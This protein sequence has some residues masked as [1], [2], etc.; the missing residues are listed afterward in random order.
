MRPN[1]QLKNYSKISEELVLTDKKK[2]NELPLELMNKMNLISPIQQNKPKRKISGVDLID[3]DEYEEIYDEELIEKDEDDFS[4]SDEEENKFKF[5]ILKNR[6]SFDKNLN[7]TFSQNYIYINNLL[8]FEKYNINKSFL[9]YNNYFSNNLNLKSEDNSI[10]SEGNYSNN[11][12]KENTGINENNSISFNNNISNLSADKSNT[13]NY[14]LQNSVSQIT[15]NS[16][17]FNLNPNMFFTKLNSSNSKIIKT[18]NNNESSYN[19][20]SINT[21]NNIDNMVQKLLITQS[22][23]ENASNKNS[24]NEISLDINNAPFIPRNLINQKPKQEMTSNINTEKLTN[25]LNYY[26]N[27][28]QNFDIK[29]KFVN[30]ENYFIK[31]NITNSNIYTNN[32]NFNKHLN[33]KKNISNN[34]LKNEN[35]PE[36]KIRK[37]D[38]KDYLIEMFGKLG[39]ICDKCENFNFESRTTCNR[40]LNIKE[41]KTIEEINRIRKEKEEKKKN[42]KKK[43]IKKQKSDW[44][45]LN[46]KN[47][48]Y[49]FRKKCNRCQI[50]RQDHFPNIRINSR[51]YRGVSDFSPVENKFNMGV[52]ESEDKK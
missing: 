16:L 19:S 13:K 26:G 18:S 44:L 10:K 14:L 8:K 4:S 25:K 42:K 15:D 49:G 39:W 20:N 27:L 46:C 32:D 33:L 12:I 3:K 48:N 1:K 47:L 9:S 24:L 50:E 6:K 43:K 45:C 29:N 2:L 21:S 17:N 51:G 40:C 23:I 11:L 36:P 35:N 38:Q 30:N 34:E 31:K 37:L 52:G 41:P 22:S 28:T 5:K 7:K